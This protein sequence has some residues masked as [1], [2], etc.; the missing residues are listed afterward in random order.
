MSTYGIICRNPTIN[1][2]KIASVSFVILCLKI[3]C[4][5]KTGCCTGADANIS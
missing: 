3:V 4:W 2:I 1:E 5:K